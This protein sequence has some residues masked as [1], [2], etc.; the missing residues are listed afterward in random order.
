VVL[1]LVLS[2]RFE[3]IISVGKSLTS[4][5]VLTKRW[6][7]KYFNESRGKGATDGLRSLLAVTTVWVCFGLGRLLLS[8]LSLRLTEPKLLLHALGIWID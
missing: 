8:L 7:S 3:T 4:N 5:T 6:P 2:V 1:S